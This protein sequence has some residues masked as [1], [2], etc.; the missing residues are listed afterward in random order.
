MS[1]IVIAGG[2]GFL[3]TVLTAALEAAGHDVVILTRKHHVKSKAK[4][5]FW[6]VALPTPLLWPSEFDG[7]D[8]VI[9]LCGTPVSDPW[10][11][12]NKKKMLDSRVSATQVIGQTIGNA[13]NPPAVWINAS[14]VGIYGNRREQIVDDLSSRGAGF[15]AD[16]CVAWEKAVYSTR[17]DRTRCV[18]LRI[19]VVLGPGGGAMGPLVK[20][21]KSFLGGPIGDGRQ[22][23]PWIHLYDLVQLVEWLLVTDE[24]MH[25]FRKANNRPWAPPA[26]KFALSLASKLG[27]PDSSLLLDSVRA[28]PKLALERG[29]EFAFPTLDSAMADLFS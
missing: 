29:F 14:A 11:E 10:T 27:A 15:L 17:L 7:A 24:F 4:V 8:A 25:A 26:P 23:V 18:E 6:D 5:V 2:S 19:G 1:R 3:G 9:N 16:V 13:T 22:W 28:V 12:Q 21:T 20:M